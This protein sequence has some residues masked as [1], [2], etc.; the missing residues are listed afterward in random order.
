MAHTFIEIHQP[1]IIMTLEI[2]IRGGCRE[3]VECFIGEMR[4]VSTV[5]LF[6]QDDTQRVVWKGR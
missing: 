4:G 1:P 3:T 5:G 2:G 6:V